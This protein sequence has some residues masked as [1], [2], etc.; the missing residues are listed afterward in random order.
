MKLHGGKIR[1]A[2]IALGAVGPTAIR[3]RQTENFLAGQP[4][5]VAVMRQAGEIA[6]REIA[7]I[8]DVRGS[9]EYRLQLTR[10]ILLKYF[11]DL[12]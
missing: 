2:N 8:S 12:P 4:F 6:A 1:R 7:P 3:P 10:N 5:T 11:H 9:A